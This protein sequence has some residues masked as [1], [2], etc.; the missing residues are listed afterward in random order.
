MTTRDRTKEL[1]RQLVD[2]ADVLLGEYT[3][4]DGDVKVYGNQHGTYI[5]LQGATLRLYQQLS[6]TTGKTV[7]ELLMGDIERK[8]RQV[9]GEANG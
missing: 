7:D 5:R 8:C 4:K 3:P 9:L 1:A 6:A 2:E